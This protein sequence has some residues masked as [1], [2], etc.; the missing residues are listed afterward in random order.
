MFVAN[1]VIIQHFSNTSFEHHFKNTGVQICSNVITILLKPPAPANGTVNRSAKHSIN[2]NNSIP[3]I[4][5]S[6]RSLQPYRRARSSHHAPPQKKRR[7]IDLSPTPYPLFTPR[8]V[9]VTEALSDF[10][11]AMVCAQ[12]DPKCEPSS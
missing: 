3:C 11:C 2:V 1:L 10:I 9:V 6:T 5:L 12:L 8:Q 4:S 7:L